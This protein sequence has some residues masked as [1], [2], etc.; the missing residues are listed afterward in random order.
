MLSNIAS[1]LLLA[2]TGLLPFPR[3]TSNNTQDPRLLAKPTFPWDDLLA[4]ETL[5]YRDCYDDFQCAMLQVPM[6]WNAEEGASNKT[7][8]IAIIRLPATV[9]VTDTRYGGAVI[10]NPGKRYPELPRPDLV[11]GSGK[12]VQTLVSAGPTADNQTAKHF[13]I[14]SFDPRGVANTRPNFLCFPSSLER[15]S[16]YTTLSAYGSPGNSYEAFSN[17]WTLMRT[18]ADSCS[19]RAIEAGIGE[20]MSTSSVARDMIEIVER[21]GEWR[22]QEARRLLKFPGNSD[23]NM[24]SRVE[25]QPGKEMVQFWGLSYGTVLGA[26]LADMYPKRVKRVVLDGVADS[27]DWYK[28][29]LT[30]HLQDTDLAITKFAEYCWLGGRENCALYHENGVTSIAEQFENI[31]QKLLDNPVGV[32]GTDY[33]SASLMTYSSLKA[34]FFSWSYKP[35]QGFSKFADL[36]AALDK[37]EVTASTSKGRITTLSTKKDRSGSCE[38]D[39][40]YS[41][42]CSQDGPYSSACKK[43]G[44]YSHACDPDYGESSMLVIHDAISCTDSEDR[45]NTTKEE[46]WN[47]TQ[48]MMKQS[49]T[50]GDSFTNRLA[51]TQWHAR[52]SWRYEGNFNATTAHP[53]LLLGNVVDPVTPLR[54]AYKMSKGFRGSVVLASDIVGHTSLNGVR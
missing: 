21:H 34:K 32:P 1:L 54:N 6:D 52:D 20:H 8:E 41:H 38:E 22:E 2:S 50:M 46:Y 12:R 19:Q 29:D 42:A 18:F 33:T 37:G 10:I 51:C 35:L 24:L 43:D 36:L 40:P 9:P 7:V 53:I 27:F 39:E 30:A 25:H 13:D 45:T 3:Q 47:Y 17:I 15:E 16:Y 44:P 28:G 11:V 23:T 5:V 48:A 31:T 14:V 26:T 49:K 4:S